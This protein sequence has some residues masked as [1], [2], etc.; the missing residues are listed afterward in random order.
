MFQ[1][2]SDNFKDQKN[3]GMY[4]KCRRITKRWWITRVK[5]PPGGLSDESRKWYEHQKNIYNQVLKA[6]MTINAQVH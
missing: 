3:S 2:C 4:L 6:S 5:V 1:D